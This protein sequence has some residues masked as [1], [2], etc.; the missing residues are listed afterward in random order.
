MFRALI[1]LSLLLTALLAG[2]TASSDPRAPVDAQISARAGLT[3]SYILELLAMGMDVREYQPDPQIQQQ[4]MQHYA[5][6]HAKSLVVDRRLAYIGTYNLDPRSENLN[7]E[8]G[9]SIHDA[10][11]AGAVA[12][13]I[14]T[15]RPDR[16]ASFGTRLRAWLWSLLPLRPLL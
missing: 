2:Q 13:A 9:V 1:A 10:A 15:D 8:V 16:F 4:V 7:T 14:E 12:D 11:Q 6:L 3:G 5:A